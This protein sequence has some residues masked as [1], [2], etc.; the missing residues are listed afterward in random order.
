MKRK[1]K[2]YVIFIF[3]ITTAAILSWMWFFTTQSEQEPILAETK[4]QMEQ[5]KVETEPTTSEKPIQ[6]IELELEEKSQNISQTIQKEPVKTMSMQKSEQQVKEPPFD[7]DKALNEMETANIVFNVPTKINIDDSPEIQLILSLSE[8]I[9]EV[10]KS[11]LAEGEKVGA[12]IRVSQI[13]EADLSGQMFDIDE[14]TPK[15]QAISQLE[16]TEWK[17]EIMP[18]EKGDL[19]LHLTLTAIIEVDGEKTQRTIKTFDKLVEVKVLPKQQII[20]F[21]KGNW[22]WLWAAILVPLA[23]WFWKKKKPDY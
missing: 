19:K 16:R 14:I 21:V 13:M 17:W 1:S 7:I 10:K 11:L 15:R 23:G 4:G 20:S 22:E 2:V 3:I 9:E 6:K 5:P 8:T 12:N 18:K